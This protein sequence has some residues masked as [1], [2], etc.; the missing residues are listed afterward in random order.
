MPESLTR[1]RGR[2]GIILCAVAIVTACA[3]TDNSLLT[4]PL[5]P[6]ANP[7]EYSLFDPEA[8]FISFGVFTGPAGTY[9]FHT[10]VVGGGLYAGGGDL[11]YIFT[12]PPTPAAAQFHYAYF[13]V[14]AS[15]WP[16]SLTALVTINEVTIP[17][18]RVVDS[19]RV[20]KNGVFLP[21]VLL[22]NS[23]TVETGYNDV[24][25]VKFYHSE[26]SAPPP[27]PPGNGCT[28]GYWK[29]SQHFDSW[30]PTG[31]PPTTL[32]SK[33]FSKASL[34]TL[35][36]KQMG[37]YTLVEALNF[38]GGSS[39]AGAAQILLRAAVAAELNAKY[40]ALG[41]PMTAADIVTAVNNALASANR[42]TMLTL[43][44]QLDDLNN[45]GCTLN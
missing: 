25:F 26:V 5:S 28:P 36:G 44:A 27:P 22:T 40:N 2:A 35:D 13:P 20:V 30:V 29:Q 24:I 21:T 8:G 38:Q 9:S 32:V 6:P 45:L 39:L 33:V 16:G 37:K 7:A 15:S 11:S 14:D 1:R 23:A 34:Y 42:A 12:T 18:E 3:Q 41:Y 17:P 10:D 19:I 31:L 43:A 4:A